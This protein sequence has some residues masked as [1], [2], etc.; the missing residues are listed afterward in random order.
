MVRRMKKMK[1]KRVSRL[2]TI[3]FLAELPQQSNIWWFWS[4]LSLSAVV[5]AAF[6]PELVLSS[7]ISQGHTGRERDEIP[8]MLGNSGKC[9]RSAAQNSSS[10]N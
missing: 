7:V 2:L 4:F 6:L 8:A 5:A 1:L 10:G 3:Q 9:E